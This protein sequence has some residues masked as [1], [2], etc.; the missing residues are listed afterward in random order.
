MRLLRKG[1]RRVAAPSLPSPSRPFATIGGV[2]GRPEP[3]EQAADW[4]P[5]IALVPGADLLAAYE[6]ETAATRELFAGI[7]EEASLRRYAPEKWSIREVVIHVADGERIYAYRVL[8]FARGDA[9]PLASY[10][11]HNYVPPSGADGRSWRDLV[12]E[13]ESVRR[14]TVTLLRGLPE[15]AWGRSGRAAGNLVSVRGLAWFILGHDIHHRR[16][17]RERYL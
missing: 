14:A 16:L 2:I 7:S 15:E 4:G 1:T 10:E 17:I 3:S 8:R 11:S 13:W 12:G 5:Y 6:P 9:T